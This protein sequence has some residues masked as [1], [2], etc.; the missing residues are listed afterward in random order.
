M[1]LYAEWIML[2]SH[3]GIIARVFYAF[4]DFYLVAVSGLIK[5]SV[6]VC[7]WFVEMRVI[8]Q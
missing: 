3:W 2:I 4:H 5:F 7:V 1:C 6:L 8:E